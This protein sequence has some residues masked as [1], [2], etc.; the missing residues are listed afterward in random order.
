M[1]VHDT[2]SYGQNIAAIGPF[3]VALIE[4]DYSDNEF[5]IDWV[6]TGNI[7]S[8]TTYNYSDQCSSTSDSCHI[9]M[10]SRYIALFADS[11]SVI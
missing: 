2:A 10:N 11:Y 3:G 7:Y 8:G 1:Y 9:D 5:N 4:Y 6:S